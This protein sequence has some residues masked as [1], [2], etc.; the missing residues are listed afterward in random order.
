[1][2][3]HLTGQNAARAL[4]MD[5]TM[6]DHNNT[7]SASAAE[8]RFLKQYPKPHFNLFLSETRFVSL[9]NKAIRLRY[10]MLA[11]MHAMDAI[12]RSVP[13]CAHVYGVQEYLFYK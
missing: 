11:S 8:A 10:E 1:M 2:D 12:A 9:I 4:L 13:V 5:E 6:D 3:S 7:N